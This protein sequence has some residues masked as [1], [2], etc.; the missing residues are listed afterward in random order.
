MNNQ[1]KCSYMVENGFRVINPTDADYFCTYSGSC[2]SKIDSPYMDKCLFEILKNG[3]ASSN[4][5]R[6]I[7][8][9]ELKQD[10]WLK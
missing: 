10:G 4:L 5:L 3:N 7:K 2:P 1:I 9:M 6:R 8:I